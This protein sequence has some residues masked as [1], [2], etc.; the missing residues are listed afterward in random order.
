MQPCLDDF[1]TT[2]DDYAEMQ[3]Y[4]ARQARES[5]WARKTVSGLHI[6]PLDEA[7]PLYTDGKAFA[8][9][10][11][12]VAVNDTAKNLGLALLTENGYLPIR[13]TAYKSNPYSTGRRSEALRFRSCKSPSS[14]ESSTNAFH[15]TNRKRCCW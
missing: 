14:P 12:Q 2:F 1:H 9:N 8:P 7:S 11:S 6:E 4:H 3:V 15:C 13:N 10:V 5:K